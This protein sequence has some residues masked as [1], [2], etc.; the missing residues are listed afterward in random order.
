MSDQR[1]LSGS[2]KAET[3]WPQL[4]KGSKVTKVTTRVRRM[5]DLCAMENRE[6]IISGMTCGGCVARAKKA[7]ESLEGV[8]EAHVQLEVPQARLSLEKPFTLEELQSALNAAGSY[9]LSAV[10]PRPRRS[11]RSGYRGFVQRAIVF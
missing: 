4:A 1:R 7:F 8:H 10:K 2:E 11:I 6:F 3:V 9:T 5:C